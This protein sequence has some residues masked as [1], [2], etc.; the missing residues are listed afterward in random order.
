MK[1]LTAEGQERLFALL[2]RGFEIYNAF[3]PGAEGEKALLELRDDIR[4]Q[5]NSE[6]PPETPVT[7][8]LPLQL[9]TYMMAASKHMG[10]ICMAISKMDAEGVLFE[11]GAR[12]Q[13]RNGPRAK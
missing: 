8:T 3:P 6:K 7:L 4:R 13:G 12:K 2:S 5:M 11:Q 9:V 1:K 10:D